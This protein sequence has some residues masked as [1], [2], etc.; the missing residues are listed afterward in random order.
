MILVEDI[1]AAL[2]GA[3][4]TVAADAGIDPGLVESVTIM[5]FSDGEALP[6]DRLPVPGTGR[7]GWIGDV[8][9]DDGELIGS[10][11]WLLAREKQ[12]PEVLR[13]AEDYAREALQP[14][15]DAGIASAIAVEAGVAAGDRLGLD[16][17]IDRP[18]GSAVDLRFT[19]LWEG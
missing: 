19:H 13:L 5:L 4:V 14:L 7:R 9:T 17:R 2:D 12:R 15:L 3:A 6:D 10:R 8:L 16:I 18:A 11:L 1:S